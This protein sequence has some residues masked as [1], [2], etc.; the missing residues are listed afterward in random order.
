MKTLILDKKDIYKGSLIL[1]N[2]RH[3]VNGDSDSVLVP[4][5]TI[6]TDI[7]IEAKAAA[8]LSQ[9]L[10]F[11]DCKNEIIP[12]SGYRTRKEQKKIYE[13][14]LLENGI[15]FTRQYVA[16]PDSSEHQT[17]LAV[18]LGE[19]TGEIDFI[20]P[21][22]PYIG[23]FG[24]FRMNAAKYGFI[25]RYGRDKEA[26][27]GIAHEPWHF[28]YVGY[29][30]AQIIRDNNLSLEEYIAFIKD[31]PYEEKPF[32]FKEKQKEIDIF[33]VNAASEKTA[34]ELP[35]DKCVQISGNNADGFIV[36]VW[37]C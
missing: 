34:L 10:K 7:L 9:L 36:T 4:F 15:E 6:N 19:N 2:S 21:N 32:H 35:E 30:H 13:D 37:C 23:I 25:E 17:G 5:N 11:I 24:D 31:F 18:D 3:P 22:F 14:S 27:T 1:V 16:L 28:R 26:V 8:L 12:V 20:R 33:Y 29:P